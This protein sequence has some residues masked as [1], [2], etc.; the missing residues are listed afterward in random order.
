MASLPLG[1]ESSLVLG[2]LTEGGENEE[3]KAW[4]GMHAP[5]GWSKDLLQDHPLILALVVTGW[6]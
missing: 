5:P 2:T 4:G 3:E 6:F 1:P